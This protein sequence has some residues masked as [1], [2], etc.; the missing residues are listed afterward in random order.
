MIDVVFSWPLISVEYLLII[1][2]MW[3][4]ILCFSYTLY[5]HNYVWHEH[6]TI[7]PFFL[8]AIRIWLWINMPNFWTDGAHYHTKIMHIKHHKN[9]DTVN[10][11]HSPHY[12]SLKDFFTEGTVYKLEQKD[13][14]RFNKIRKKIEPCDKLSTFLKKNQYTGNW[15]MLITFLLLA[16]IPGLL[17]SLYLKFLNHYFLV[18]IFNILPHWG[19]G[20]RHPKDVSKAI[21]RNPWPFIEGLHSNHHAEGN[22][23]YINHRY[24]WFEIDFYYLQIKLLETLGLIIINETAKR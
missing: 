10:D 8:K 18:F 23:K 12:F 11:P 3:L 19:I 1:I 6:I 9:A 22:F 20:Y 24:R 16:G 21:Q 14:Y 4:Y 7:K 17:F 5:W 2:A 15:L 13:Y